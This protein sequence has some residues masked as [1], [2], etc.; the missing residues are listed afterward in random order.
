MRYFGFLLIS[1]FIFCHAQLNLFAQDIKEISFSLKFPESK[2]LLEEN[3]DLIPSSARAVGTDALNFYQTSSPNTIIENAPKKEIGLPKASG[4]FDFISTPK[5]KIYS[6]PLSLTIKRNI[7]VGVII[8][9]VSKKVRFSGHTYT[10]SGLGDITPNIK[11]KWGDENRWVMGVSAIYLKVPTGDEHATVNHGTIALPLGTGSYD[12]T[13]SQLITKKMGS[14]RFIGS[15]SYRINSKGERRDTFSKKTRDYKQGNVLNAVLGG[16][17]NLPLFNQRAWCGL[18]LETMLK[19]KDKIDGHK[20]KNNMEILDLFPYLYY[21]VKSERWEFLN[22][23]V[24]V[25]IVL[26]IATESD[27]KDPARTV[28]SYFGINSF[29]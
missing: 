18:K 27:G 15:I 24:T 29:F 11:F 26:P 5:I 25:G 9:Y 28:S 12:T 6:F 19:S 2:T 22:F 14:F 16:E 23:F 20:L 4:G 7:K 21:H 10:K 1:I 13:L 3:K 17:Y 8:P